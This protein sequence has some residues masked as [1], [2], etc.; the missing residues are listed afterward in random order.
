MSTHGVFPIDLNFNVQTIMF[1]QDTRRIVLS[2]R[3][4]DELALVCQPNRSR[5]GLADQL[6]V[7]DPV[8]AHHFVSR[9]C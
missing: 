7:I 8:S 2:S 3:I 5:I 9:V 1:Q 4:T 6:A